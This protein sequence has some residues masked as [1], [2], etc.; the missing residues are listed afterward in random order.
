M[1]NAVNAAFVLGAHGN[2]VAPLSLR[3]KRVL[4]IGLEIG[5]VDEALECGKQPLLRRPQLGAH[6][7][8]LAAGAVNHVAPLANAAPNLVDDFVARRAMCAVGGRA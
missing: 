8:Q 7:L 4:E 5:V 2:D 3:D 1:H 6:V